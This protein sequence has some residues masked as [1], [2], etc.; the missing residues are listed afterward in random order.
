MKTEVILDA[1]PVNDRW[2]RA[3][4]QAIHATLQKIYELFVPVID[5]LKDGAFGVAFAKLLIGSFWTS[6]SVVTETPSRLGQTAGVA[7]PFELVEAA[8]EKSE[9]A[10]IGESLSQRRANQGML[11]VYKV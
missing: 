9:N 6:Y 4:L 3:A 2:V 11:L 8:V 7:P 1:W 5:V 10:Q